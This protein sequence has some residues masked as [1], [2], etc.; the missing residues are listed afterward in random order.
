MSAKKDPTC[1]C[2]PVDQW[3]N[4]DKAVWF[5]AFEATDVFA[6]G[7]A[8]ARRWA[9]TS[10]RTIENGYGRWL[11]WL[12]LEG[13]F[14][15]EAKP[16]QRVSL[17]RA[18]A[19][20]AS[21]QARGNAPFTVASRLQAL[22]EALRILEPTGDWGE[23]LRAAGRVR[24]RGKPVKDIRKRL[25]PAEQVVELGFDLMDRAQEG[26][27]PTLEGARLY[28]DGLVIAA[29][30]YL[31]ERITP[32]ASMELGRHLRRSGS[33]WRLSFE[34]KEVK[35]RRPRS[36]GEWPAQLQPALELYLEVYRP[37]LLARHHSARLWVSTDGGDM[38]GNYLATRITKH[39]R[40]AFG[41]ALNPH[42]FRHLV[43]TT[44]AEEDPDNTSGVA[45]L[46]GH[47]RLETSE[48]HYIKAQMARAMSDYQTVLKKARR[49]PTRAM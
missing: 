42:G 21:L 44:V 47:A 1:R 5:A 40:D 46:L 49:A 39:T 17:E 25:Q 27:F 7:A 33:R 9:S 2:V 31:P 34:A 41:V 11:T 43:A 8:A 36:L 32:F 29:L 14:D 13:L 20:T 26:F 4:Y 6:P 37:I 15:A 12:Q 23:I 35:N 38:T 18:R 10:R 45:A 24:E 16:G 22:G 3:P 48:T 30:V 28:R 19:Y